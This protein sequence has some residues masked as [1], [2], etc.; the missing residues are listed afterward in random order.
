M[1]RLART[2]IQTSCRCSALPRYS[3][4]SG[5]V[6]CTWAIGPSTARTI[7]G[8]RHLVGRPGQPVAALGA[9]PGADDAVVLELEQDVLEE[10][11]GDVLGLGQA[12]ALDRALLAGG[13]QLGSGPH[14]VVGLRGNS[15]VASKSVGGRASA[16]SRRRA[17]SRLL[18]GAAARAGAVQPVRRVEDRGRGRSPATAAAIGQTLGSPFWTVT[19]PEPIRTRPSAVRRKPCGAL[20]ESAAPMTTP[21]DRAEEDVAGE[22]EVD[23][24]ADPVGDAGRPE[25]D[26]GV[27][28]VGA[29]DLLRREPVD[30]DQ[31]DRDHGAR[32]GRGDPDHEAGGGADHD[33]GDLVTPLDLEVGRARRSGCAGSAPGRG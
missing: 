28:D 33:R 8:D 5:G 3:I 16:P 24:A 7:V 2:A 14:R 27:E 31:Q 25:Q 21:G 32:A 1:R 15:H 13:G 12:L 22:D 9:A 4:A 20:S 26:R 17:E 29:D 23:V 18:L 30:G 10:L 6:D 11:Q 19:M